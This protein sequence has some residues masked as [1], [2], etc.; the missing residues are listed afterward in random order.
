MSAPFAA[1][2]AAVDIVQYGALLQAHN[3]QTREVL[4]TAHRFTEKGE[5]LGWLVVCGAFREVVATVTTARF[6][7]LNASSQLDGVR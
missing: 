6:A 3:R 2:A 7:L 4:G 1:M 5:P